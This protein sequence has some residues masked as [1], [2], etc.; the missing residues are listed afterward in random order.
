MKATTRITI[1]ATI[2]L[3][4]GA[5]AVPAQ[6]NKKPYTEWSD[7]EARKLLDDSPWGQTQVISNTSRMFNTGPGTGVAGGP[8]AEG[9][10]DHINFRIRFLSA[11]PVRQ[12]FSRIIEI[13]HKADMNEQL[14]AQIKAF[15]AGDFPDYIV[16]AVDV[17]STEQRGQ[18]QRATAVLQTRTTA[19]LKNNTYLVG[20][21]GQRLFLDEFQPPKKDGLGAR[22]IFPRVVEGKPFISEESGEIKFV[23]DMSGFVLNARFKVKDMMFNGKLEY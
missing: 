22:F 9:S 8:P 11:K 1:L 13:N 2:L 10:A 23:A 18:L 14:A 3:A 16:I 17:D 19:E 21:G 15:A 7:K 6:W 12:A 5:I 20:K 4:V